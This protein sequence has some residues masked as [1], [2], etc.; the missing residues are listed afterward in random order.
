MS[1]DIHETYTRK[2]EQLHSRY[3]EMNFQSVMKKLLG[4]DVERDEPVSSSRETNVPFAGEQG[5]R[6]LA[7]MVVPHVRDQPADI[8]NGE[9]VQTYLNNFKQKLQLPPVPGAKVLH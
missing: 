1:Q 3:P 5:G 7:C 9:T 8:L 6:M 4:R 2:L